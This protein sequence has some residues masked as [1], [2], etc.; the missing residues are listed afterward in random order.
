M[1]ERP[2]KPERRERRPEEERRVSA[3]LPCGVNGVAAAHGVIPL[4][5]PVEE[6]VEV[7]QAEVGV[8]AVHAHVLGRDAKAGDVAERRGTAYEP[9]SAEGL[10]LSSLSALEVIH[11]RDVH[12]VHSEF[13]RRPLHRDS[14][15]LLRRNHRPEAALH[16]DLRT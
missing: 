12:S 14:Y 15:L 7:V 1:R 16:S 4:G 11:R 8:G 2:G 9:R 10:H 3:L 5:R 6:R 13:V